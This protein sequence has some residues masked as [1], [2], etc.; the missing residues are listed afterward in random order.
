M[1]VKLLEWQ[2]FEQTELDLVALN[3]VTSWADLPVELIEVQV[4]HLHSVQIV[5]IIL[6]LAYQAHDLGS[7]FHCQRAEEIGPPGLLG[8]LHSR[9]FLLFK[10]RPRH[11]ILVQPGVAVL[12]YLAKIDR[13]Q[14]TNEWL[15]LR[16][17][18]SVP[19]CI[20]KIFCLENG[21]E[22][23]LCG[24]FSDAKFLGK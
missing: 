16:W 2:L 22:M 12:F 8:L 19:Q 9:Q 15:L 6:L 1:K 17:A 14:I 24:I 23:P 18:D 11:S 10:K 7:L 5:G 21:T 3:N 13:L 20:P 4:T